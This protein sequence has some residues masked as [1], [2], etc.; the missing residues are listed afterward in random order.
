MGLSLDHVAG[1]LYWISE[2]KEVGMRGAAGLSPTQGDDEVGVGRVTLTPRC[3]WPKHEREQ[4]VVPRSGIRAWLKR[5]RVWGCHMATV[6][7]LVPSP[8]RRCGWM[9]AGAT[10]S[11]LFCGATRSRWAWPCLR[12]GSSGLMAQSWC[13]PPGPLPRSMQCCSVPLSQ[14]SLC[15]THCSSLPVSTLLHCCRAGSVAATPTLHPWV[16]GKALWSLELTRSCPMV[17]LVL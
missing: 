10:P 6:P 13:Q 4:G 2:Y 9:A 12:A 16:L 3:P 11:T 8:S 15:C 1:R 7:C 5:A 17:C 14:L